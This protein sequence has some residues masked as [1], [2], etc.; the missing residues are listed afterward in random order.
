MFQRVTAWLQ[1]HPKVKALLL[2]LEAGAAAFLTTTGYTYYMDGSLFTA[3]GFK[4]M[5]VAFVTAE[6]MAVRAWLAP[7]PKG[8]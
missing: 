5:A 2:T 6:Y 1:A 4:R 3:N 8:S 7:P